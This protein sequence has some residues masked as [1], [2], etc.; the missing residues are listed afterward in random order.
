VRDRQI[1]RLL[2]EYSV[3]YVLQNCMP[4]SASDVAVR[5]GSGNCRNWLDPFRGQMV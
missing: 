5:C 1:D 2:Y 3:L 4:D